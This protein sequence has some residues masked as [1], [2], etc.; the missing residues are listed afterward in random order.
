MDLKFET[1]LLKVLKVEFDFILLA[2]RDSTICKINAP[3]IY[4]MIN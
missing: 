2:L 4:F 1:K 3:S